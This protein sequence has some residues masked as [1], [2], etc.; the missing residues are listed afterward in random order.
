MNVFSPPQKNLRL[1]LG[2]LTS[3]VILATLIVF[4]MFSKEVVIGV[5]NPTELKSLQIS[6]I[7]NRFEKFSYSS[8]ATWNLKTSFFIKLLTPTLFQSS[9]LLGIFRCKSLGKDPMTSAQLSKL[10][11]KTVFFL[12][13]D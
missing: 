3:L 7:R 8:W 1:T 4:S 10:C 12:V 13:D 6:E 9:F 5:I 11:R 2:N